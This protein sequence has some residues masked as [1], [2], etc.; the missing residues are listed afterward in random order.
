MFFKSFNPYKT[1]IM[2]GSTINYL[3]TDHLTKMPSF[4]KRKYME[5]NHKNDWS[6]H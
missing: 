5:Y 3:R 4:D 2:T 1:F 6:L